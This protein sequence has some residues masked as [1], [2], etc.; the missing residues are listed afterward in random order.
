MTVVTAV[1]LGL[2]GYL[3]ARLYS[4]ITENT[5]LKTHVAALKRQL[6]QRR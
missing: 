4:V 2:S 1:L 3:G 5:A 6:A